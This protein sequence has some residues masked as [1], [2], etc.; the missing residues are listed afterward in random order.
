MARNKAAW[1][2]LRTRRACTPWDW[3]GSQG[4]EPP[5]SEGHR[6]CHPRAGAL[7]RSDCGS[8][9]AFF[10]PTGGPSSKVHKKKTGVESKKGVTVRRL[11]TSLD[12][13]VV[14]YA[15]I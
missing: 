9:A 10:A 5:C 15:R 3:L 13:H 12:E 2:N 4:G 11:G 7:G 14:N 6:R 8:V 1:G